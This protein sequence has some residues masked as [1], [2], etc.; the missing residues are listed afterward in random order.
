MPQLSPLNWTFLF[1]LFWFIIF[2]TFA[3]IWWQ[4]SLYYK[5]SKSS[6]S[7]KPTE[8]KWGW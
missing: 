8:N 3:L 1:L 2:L 6:M 4:K 7:S 5:A